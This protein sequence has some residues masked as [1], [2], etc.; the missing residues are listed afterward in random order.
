M[1]PKPPA[2]PATA[3]QDPTEALRGL[4]DLTDAG[5]DPVTGEPRFE[6]HTP[7]QVGPRVF[8]GQV[9]G[10]ALAAAT[11][12]VPAARSAH[13]LHGYFI[14]PGDALQPITFTVETLRDGR[15]FSVRRVLA[16]QNE[17]AILALTC[18]FQEPTGSA[19]DHQV[20]MPEGVPRPEDLPTTADVLGGI[21]HP[22]AQEWA[23]SRP[24][25]IRHV[26][27][28][29]YVDPAAETENRNMVWMKT[30]TP[31]ADDPAL[32]L[33]ALTYASDYTLLEP[34]LRQHGVAWIQPGMSVASL[35][36]AMWFHR[37]ARVDEWLLYVQDSP[38]A[39][40]ARGLGRGHVFTR[41]G[42]LV[43][44]VA[45]EGMIRLPEG[46]AATAAKAKNVAQRAAM[47]TVLRR[48]WRG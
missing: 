17:K 39:Q 2:R 13:S 37:P 38:T 33:A 7:A 45:Q 28:A 4:L 21:N 16:S 44:T 32:H 47:K 14:R 8:G 40:G 20:A 27:P 24:F 42:E 3:P 5:P 25:D 9:L 26:T 35:D 6:G 22:V 48:T 1:S 15:S 34:I 10:Q 46:H 36:H 19:L 12:T 43:A 41:D 11:R 18:S 30:F 31:L 23:W 29:I